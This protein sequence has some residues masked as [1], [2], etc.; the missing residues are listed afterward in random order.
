V[1]HSG[2]SF[3]GVIVFYVIVFNVQVRLWDS[4]QSDPFL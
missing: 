2:S 3:E 1:I 4:V